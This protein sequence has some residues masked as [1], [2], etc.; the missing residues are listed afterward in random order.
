MRAGIRAL[1][2]Y[3]GDDAAPDG[4]KKLFG[5]VTTEMPPL[6]G[7][8]GRRCS[9]MPPMATSATG[10]L[11]QPHLRASTIPVHSSA[12][13]LPFLLGGTGSTLSPIP[14]VPIPVVVA[15]VPGLPALISPAIP[16][17]PPPLDDDKQAPATSPGPT[18]DETR[19]RP[20]LC[21]RIQSATGVRPPSARG[22][23][24]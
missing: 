9:G 2:V 18:P 24:V 13:H 21:R 16:A 1:R 19:R 3:R 23:P 12:R 22:R 6:T 7:L 20:P 8:G 4:A 14:L 17:N 10:A 5:S 11:L 15:A